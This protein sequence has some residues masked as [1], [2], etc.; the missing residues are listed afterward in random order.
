MYVD[1]WGRYVAGV[2]G[3]PLGTMLTVAG[4]ALPYV[5]GVGPAASAALAGAIAL[6]KGKSL[7]DAALAAIRG[8]LP[9][10]AQ[11]AF[12]V[13]VAVASGEPVDKA[14]KD[15]LLGT[16]PGG[17]DAYAEGMAAWEAYGGA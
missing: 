9:G 10:P 2:S 15:A 6:A 5:P 17:K 7:D 14:S 11:L 8:A 1:N 3:D 12:D 4:V 16:I 13:G